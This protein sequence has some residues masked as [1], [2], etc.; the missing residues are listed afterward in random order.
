MGKPLV[1]SMVE[2]GCNVSVVCRRKVDE[3]DSRRL[4]DSGGGYFYGD[5]KD[6][7]FMDDVLKRHYDAIVDFCIYTSEEFK[8]RAGSFLDNTDQYVALSTAAVYA[9]IPTPKNESYPRYI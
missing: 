5:A 2:S 7:K 8:E 4:Q 1:K 9:D 6:R 3:K